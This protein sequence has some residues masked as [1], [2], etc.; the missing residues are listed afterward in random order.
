MMSKK[1]WLAL[2]ALFVLY[3]LLGAALFHHIE[4]E[5]EVQ[6]RQQERAERIEIHALLSKH[7]AAGEPAS[8]A[9]LL[10]KLSEYCGRPMS[11]HP[12][13]SD[14]VDFE[15]FVWDFYNSVFF[16]ITVVSTIGYG[17]LSP[18]SALGRL[19]MIL[20][21][22]VGIPM[23][24][25]VLAT[26]AEFFSTA[27]LKV[28][29]RYKT[30]RSETRAG[31]VADIVLYLIPG[32]VV[33]IFLPTG[34][35]MHFEGW[36][37][38]ESLYYAFVTLTTIGFG[39]FVADGQG[40]GQRR[41]VRAVQ[42]A[43]AGVDRVR[44]G[45]P[46]HAAGLHHARHAL[47]ADGAP[48]APP[49]RQPEAHAEQAVDQPHARR[50]LPAPRAQRA[51]RHEA[52]AR[53]QGRR[54]GGLPGAHAQQ[55]RAHAGRPAGAGHRRVAQA[56]QLGDGGV[57]APAAR[58]ER[59]RPAAHRPRRH[60][61]GRRDAHR[62]GRAAG[63][64]GEQ[65]GR[66]RG[67]AG[68]QRR[69][70][71]GRRGRLEPGRRAPAGAGGLRGARARAR[72]PQRPGRR[73]D[74]VGGAALPPRARA[75]EG[76]PQ[77]PG[78]PR[79]VG[80]QAVHLPAGGGAAQE[81]A[82]GQEHR[83]PGGGTAPRGAPSHHAPR[84][85]GDVAGRLPARRQLAAAPRGDA[86]AGLADVTLHAPDAHPGA[87]PPDVAAAHPA[88]VP[89][90]VRQTLLGAP[91]YQHAALPTPAATAAYQTAGAAPVRAPEQRPAAP[92]Q[93]GPGPGLPCL[94]EH[95]SLPRD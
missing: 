54:G 87:G 45:L 61:Q 49:G 25:I 1:Q 57:A 9:Q 68:L 85:R 23:N 4:S 74:L 29:R 55:Q 69:R 62:A 58:D 13:G 30:K 24:G 93:V 21:A 63:A 95:F 77:E 48:G 10:Q 91:R 67:R 60:L 50:G 71:P 41:A 22:L 15:P 78:A 86:A 5:L 75:H 64:R 33:F 52:Q 89:A 36:T 43:A 70:H 31:L 34:V 92:P 26:L 3:L 65:P 11:V 32:F 38:D 81:A 79:R 16:V 47:Q 18:S 84:P 17:N 42:G 66:R 44:P 53:L 6:R 2:L 28:H 73:V 20:Y 82:Q 51:L 46:G 7:Y 14:A 56:R 83:R 72:A 12:N 35:F 8:Q 37:F 39:D 94:P 90:P 59:L 40:A 88:R 80:A 76:A 19:L 27:L